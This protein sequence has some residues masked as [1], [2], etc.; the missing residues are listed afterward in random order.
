VGNELVTVA[1]SSKSGAGAKTK[2]GTE[3]RG[4]K[5]GGPK[6]GTATV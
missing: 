1:V 4:P 3:K 5:R 2:R 6:R